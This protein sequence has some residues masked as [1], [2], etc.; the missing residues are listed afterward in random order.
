[1]HIICIFCEHSYEF[2][3]VSSVFFFCYLV[4]SFTHF[5]SISLSFSLL[6]LPSQRNEREKSWHLILSNSNAR[7]EPTLSTRWL[8]TKNRVSLRSIYS[9][10][11]S[12]GV[13]FVVVVLLFPLSLQLKLQIVQAQFRLAFV[14]HTH[15]TIISVDFRWFCHIHTFTVSW[16]SW[17]KL[18]FIPYRLNDQNPKQ[19][20][21]REFVAATI[22]EPF[23]CAHFDMI[24]AGIAL[25]INALN[26]RFTVCSLLYKFIWWQY[27]STGDIRL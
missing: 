14:H 23:L 24:F 11:A 21:C 4:L 10:C 26:D 9:V 1:M 20:Q 7:H 27:S 15:T 5:L 17:E 18:L 19:K 16:R 6:R 13:V 3:N 22:N 8:S 2:K 12:F 25:T